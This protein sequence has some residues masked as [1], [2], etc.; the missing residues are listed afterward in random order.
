MLVLHTDLSVFK[1]ISVCL[2]ARMNALCCCKIRS[3]QIGKSSKFSKYLRNCQREL[4]L[5]R[6]P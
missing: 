4:E 2:R 1:T 5:L 6:K 3:K